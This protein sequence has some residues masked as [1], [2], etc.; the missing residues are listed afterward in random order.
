ML[1]PLAGSPARG[2]SASVRLSSRRGQALAPTPLLRPPRRRRRAHG[3]LRR[4]GDARPVRG[5]DPRAPRRAIGLRRLRRLAHGADPRRRPD[6]STSCCRDCSRTI[7]TRLGDGEAQYTLLTND[8]GGIVDD[9]IAYRIN[10]AHYLLVVNAGNREAAYAWL[11]EREIRGSEVRTPPTSTR[12]SPCRA[13]AAI[14]TARPAR[15]AGVHARDGR[16]GRHR[17]DGLPHRA[18]RARPG[19]ELM[20]PDEDAVGAVGRGRRARRD[21]RAGSARATRSASRSA[22]RC[23]GTTSRP[24]RTRSRP[25]SAGPARS[26]RSSP[27][28]RSCGGSRRTG[29][30]RRLV[31]FVMEEKAVPRQ[32]MAIEGGGEVTSGTHSPMLDSGIGMGYVPAA[33]AAPDTELEIDVRGKPR[34]ARIVKK[35]IYRE[36]ELVA[37]ESY[38]DDLQYHPEH[39]WARI[40]GDEA[41][42]GHHVVRAGRAR[43][44][45]PLRGA[46]RSGRPSR[47][48]RPTARSSPSRPSPT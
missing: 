11:K 31:A 25:G 33:R 42:L 22:T 23:T 34:Q 21:A 12:C 45:R 10:P 1:D 37:D 27:A 40:E 44:A 38:P 6:G 48:T 9:L 36:G 39:D 14:A 28:R 4:L 20:C 46:R 3:S 2:P 35:P 8:T 15:C 41:V 13:R 29:P 30:S 7:S 19:V 5:R 47:R 26:T 32:G 18:T 16:G 17:G 43:R 24:T